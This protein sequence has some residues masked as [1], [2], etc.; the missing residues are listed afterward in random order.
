MSPAE[1]EIFRTGEGPSEDKVHDGKSKD[2]NFGEIKANV[3][4]DWD[5]SCVN[6]SGDF[7]Q[8]EVKGRNGRVQT[9][10][11]FEKGHVEVFLE[12]EQQSVRIRGI[13]SSNSLTVTH[14]KHDGSTGE[15]G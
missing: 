11:G 10:G 12:E 5:F 15:V 3:H 4:D 1:I 14:T 7:L 6:V 9:E 8:Y 2:F 13:R